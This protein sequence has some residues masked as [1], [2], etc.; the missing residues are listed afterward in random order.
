MRVPIET[1][2]EMKLL[3][4]KI[5]SKE[6]PVYI[7]CRP[8]PNVPQNECFP[9]VEAKVKA[10]GGERVLGWQ[11]WHGQL[12]I[13]AEFH[14][15]WKTPANEFL[16]IAPKPFPIEQIFFVAD[17]RARYEG[18]QINNIRMN[19]TGNP[20]VD[21]FISVHDAVFRIENK[22][23]RA[24]QHQLS[25]SGKEVDAHHKLNEAKPMLQTMALQ[26]YTRNSRC[27]CGSGEKYKV[28]HGKTIK[29]LINNF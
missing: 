21:D 5:G 9:L 24:F 1:T 2:E 7:S 16:D 3:L 28:C 10:E 18:K 22:G 27:L 12:L 17:P 29:K 20:L 13:E 26:G 11:I 25:L 14:A 19:I 8:I 15:V 23:K 6:K 4:S